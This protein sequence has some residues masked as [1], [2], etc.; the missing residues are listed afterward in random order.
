M[1]INKKNIYNKIKDLKSYISLNLNEDPKQ[2]YQE[3][4]KLENL[5]KIGEEDVPIEF[6]TKINVDY[7]P[8]NYNIFEEWVSENYT[9][10]FERKYLPV[11]WT[12]YHVNNKYGTIK[13]IVNK[14]QNYIDSLDRNI[15]EIKS[16]IKNGQNHL[17]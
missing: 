11:H 1:I 10:N 5:L 12:S 7:P 2:T 17:I 4:N 13:N 8:E 15:L 16:L 6:K 9:S 3:I 14:L